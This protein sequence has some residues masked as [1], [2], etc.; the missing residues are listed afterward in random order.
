MSRAKYTKLNDGEGFEVKSGEIFKLACC[1]CGLVHKVNI[2]SQGKR[3][4][5]AMARDKR[6]TAAK[7]RKK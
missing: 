2:V 7:R 6:A 5:V 1:D 4:G 3:I